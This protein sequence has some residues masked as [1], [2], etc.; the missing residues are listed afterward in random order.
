MLVSQRS[1]LICLIWAYIPRNTRVLLQVPA[2]PFVLEI[3]GSS[4]VHVRRKVKQQR[5]LAVQFIE[6]IF[7]CCKRVVLFLISSHRADLCA[8]AECLLCCKLCCFGNMSWSDPNQCSW[9]VMIETDRS[10]PC[11]LHTLALFIIL[12]HGIKRWEAS[13]CVHSGLEQLATM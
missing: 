3:W 13:V 11:S 8:N 5:D 4:I 1:P 7:D 6:H 10:S 12:F 9:R 2:A